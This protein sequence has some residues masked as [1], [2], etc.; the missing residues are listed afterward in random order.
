MHMH[1]SA[2]HMDESE[3]WA[4]LLLDLSVRVEW[5][6]QALDG[7]PGEDA[8]AALGRLRRY[9]CALEELHGALE[10]VE[11][12]R[13]VLE[14]LFLL[15]GPLA[16]Y[17]SRLYAWCAELGDDFE[18]MAGALRNRQPTTIVFS[19]H[20]INDSYARFDQMMVSVRRH[21]SHERHRID[22]AKLQSFDRH[23][24]ELFWATEWLHM[25]LARS[26][27]E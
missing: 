26:P 20:A 14:P 11:L 27:G 21:V 24:E 6:G 3:F 15:E 8:S 5:I 10:R 22:R 4:R 1:M 13:P 7:L 19:H 12:H 17:L 25:T 2:G 16:A 18:R 9:A 23:L